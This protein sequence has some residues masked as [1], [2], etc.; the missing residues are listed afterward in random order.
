MSKEDWIR[1]YERAEAEAPEGTAEAE[2]C[3]QADERLA[4]RAA[5]RI[6]AATD[7]PR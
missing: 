2:L 3:R 5:A 6:E 7:D 1:C 4:D